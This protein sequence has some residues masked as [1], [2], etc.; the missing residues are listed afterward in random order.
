MKRKSVSLPVSDASSR[1]RALLRTA[2]AGALLAL[3]QA[4]TAQQ[5]Y[6]G[7]APLNFDID[8]GLAQV[9]VT[10]FLKE[11]WDGGTNV[12]HYL[13]SYQS[14]TGS[15][16]S[17]CEYSPD[18]RGV[19]GRF[20]SGGGP[21]C[22]PGPSA[23]HISPLNLWQLGVGVA[24]EFDS[25]WKVDAR[26]S[27]RARDNHADI[28]GYGWSEMTA[29]V[30]NPAYG[31][32]RAG[33]QTTRTWSRSDNFSWPIGLSSAWSETGAGYGLMDQSLRYTTKQWE[34]GEGKLV[35]EMT[36]GTNKVAYAHNADLVGYNENPPKPWL[37]EMFFQYSR[38]KLLI[39]Y[40]V[41]VS[42]GGGQS[43]WAKGPFNGDV[44]NAD[45]LPNYK[46]PAEDVQIL[47]GEYYFSPG[48]KYTFGARRS[49][50]SGEVYQCDYA[51]LN[52]GTS[53]CYFPSGFNNGVDLQGHAAHVY[54][55]MSG[56]S[57]SEDVWTYSAGGVRL[58]KAYTATPTEY[59]QSNG[60]TYVNL[61]ASRQIPELSRR[62]SVYGGVGFLHFDRLD[63]APLSMPAELANWSVDPR[64]HSS[65]VSFTVGINLSL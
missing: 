57:Y 5:A 60:A 31:E 62:L 12:S 54:D 49:Y 13:V 46:T 63:P 37:G 3:G 22:Q 23:T 39:E 6:F 19:L 1:R 18:P 55:F 44:G 56:I 45:N 53:G 4:A 58:S 7:D 50:W 29:A 21:F 47:Q 32:L 2:V 30:S 40:T 9:S 17:M 15:A 65:A 28:S 43:S 10:G 52:N 38:D 35:A 27:Y 48:W 24:H 33:R 16:Q 34:T 14:G 8:D 42:R 20:S 41:Q 61:Q 59:G 25:A 11:E 51:P 64:V 36:V 26:V